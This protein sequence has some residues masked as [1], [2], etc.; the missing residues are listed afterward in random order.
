MQP[1]KG[2]ATPRRALGILSILS[3]VFS[4]LALVGPTLASHA[5]NYNAGD[6]EHISHVTEAKSSRPGWRRGHV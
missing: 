3:L 2:S 6:N 5:G 4:M 1:S